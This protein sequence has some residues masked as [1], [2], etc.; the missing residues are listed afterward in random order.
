LLNRER[1]Y[2][3][4]QNY[5]TT[6]AIAQLRERIAPLRDDLAEVAWAWLDRGARGSSRLNPL[7]HRELMQR[8]QQ[9]NDEERQQILTA[10]FPQIAVYVEAAWQ[11]HRHLPYQSY[12]KP[13]RT[14]SSDQALQESRNR[15]MSSLLRIVGEYEQEITWYAAWAACLWREDILSILLAGAISVGD[16]AGEE[17]FAILEASALGEYPIGSMGGVSDL[18]AADRRSP[19]RLETN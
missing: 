12:G 13:F 9:L 17:V 15:W 6:T 10:L 18:G 2:Q 1:A 3:E 4:L 16:A 5:R 19:G 7:R 14:A 8:W 11:L